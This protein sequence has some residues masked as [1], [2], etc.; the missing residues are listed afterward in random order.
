MAALG[1]RIKA[2]PARVSPVSLFRV[3]LT[4]ELGMAHFVAHLTRDDF[5]L[6]HSDDDVEWGASKMLTDGHTIF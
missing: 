6:F 3:W 5:S 4:S 1:A 2:V